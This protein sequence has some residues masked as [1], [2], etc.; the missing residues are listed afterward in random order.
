[1]LESA[2][3][4]LELLKL[5]GDLP[6]RSRPLSVEVLEQTS[7]GS[8]RLEKLVL[9]LNGIEKVPAYFVKPARSKGRLPAVLFCHS[10]G[11]N[12]TLGKDE[13]LQGN[14]YMA[15]PAY[16]QELASR[17]YAA[18]CIDSW[19][20][21]ERATR[22]ESSIFKDM[23]WRGRVMW[24]MMVYDSIRALD[25]LA[26]RPDVDAGRIASLGMSMGSTMSWWVAALDER[27]K[28]CVDLCC[29]TDFDAL[30]RRQ[31]LDHHGIYYYVPGLL[32]HFTTAQIN[33]LIV[34]RPHLSCA[35]RHDV[36]TPPEGL[37]T[38]D[39]ILQQ[40]YARAGAPD[41]WKLLRFDCAHQELT[42]MR[43]A[44]VDFLGCW[45]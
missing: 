41:A 44:V 4:R 26:S 6:D 19:G 43:H 15:K 8:F 31:W 10:H 35:G 7:R 32:K 25:Y 13:L 12:Y 34:P 11:G 24:G 3:R 38:I 14:D 9:D 45:L 30:C 20:F 28:V 2:T 33:E 17:G 18:L 29:L 40:A 39:A 27:I 5:L 37:D 22:S 23:L 16:A 42:S 1:M 21:G 36:L